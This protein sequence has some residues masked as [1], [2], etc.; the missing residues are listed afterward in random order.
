M[1]FHTELQKLIDNEISPPVD[2][3]IEIAKAHARALD[4][5]KKRNENIS[6]QIEEIYDIVKKADDNEKKVAMLEKNG[7][8]L[9][10]SLVNIVDLLDLILSAAKESDENF[11]SAVTTKLDESLKACSI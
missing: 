1:D 5:I 4:D 9:I 7:M 2:P 11:I 8:L 3:I 6:F 10:K